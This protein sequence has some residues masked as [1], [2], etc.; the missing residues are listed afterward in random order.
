MP[1]R[2]FARYEYQMRATWP[3]RLPRPPSRRRLSP[4]NLWRGLVMLAKV[5]WRLGVL[6]DYRAIFWKFALPLLKR[7][8]IEAILATAV[9]A[10]HLI[11]FSRDACAGRAN[12]SNYA[13]KLR[14]LE[15]VVGP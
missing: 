13:P 5:F 10:H 3:N 11:M 15:E 1:E 9:S 4:L 7:G 12:A 14:V 2:L 8:D 6:A